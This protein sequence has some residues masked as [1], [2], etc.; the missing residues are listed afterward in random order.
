MTVMPGVRITAKSAVRMASRSF[1][2]ARDLETESSG[3][4]TAVGCDDGIG[5]PR[6]HRLETRKI[7]HTSK[8]LVVLPGTKELMRI[9]ASNGTTCTSEVERF[10]GRSSALTVC[11]SRKFLW[12]NS[13]LLWRRSAILH[14]HSGKTGKFGQQTR[15]WLQ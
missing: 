7:A 15:E 12:Q 2:L 8:R 13:K 3:S 4:H 1:V 9:P 6:L 11:A 14:L 10:E 5:L